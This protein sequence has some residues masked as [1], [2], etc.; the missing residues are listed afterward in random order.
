MSIEM[1]LSWER[2]STSITDKLILSMYRFCV[3]N[4]VPLRWECF[5]TL[6]A[7]ETCFTFIISLFVIFG[8]KTSSNSITKWRPQLIRFL[9]ELSS[10]DLQGDPTSAI[11]LAYITLWA[12]LPPWTVFTWT[13]RCNLLQK[14]LQHTSHWEIFLIIP[15]LL[16]K[17]TNNYNFIIMFPIPS[18]SKPWEDIPLTQSF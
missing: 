15:H 8:G 4:Q 10:H 5:G 2:L 6:R 7:K 16:M 12:N 1:I 13:L 18:L 9:H 14:S 3:S 17:I 11:L